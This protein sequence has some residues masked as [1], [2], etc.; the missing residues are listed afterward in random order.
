MFVQ[1]HPGEATG[2]PL[3]DPVAPLSVSLYPAI[4]HM[5]PSMPSLG[6]GPEGVS[7]DAHVFLRPC[8][9]LTVDL[10]VMAWRPVQE[11]AITALRACLP[12]LHHLA[13]WRLGGPQ[14]GLWHAWLSLVGS[15]AWLQCLA[16]SH[17]ERLCASEP[18]S[19][20]DL[21]RCVLVEH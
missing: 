20:A 8:P 3:A 9:V 12:I 1:C 18:G 19:L 5:E 4:G 16:H 10:S 11:V 21:L 13:P 15:E 17:G 2:V 7:G 14:C 6:W